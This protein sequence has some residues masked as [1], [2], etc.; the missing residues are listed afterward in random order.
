[1]IDCSHGNS[2]KQ[3]ENQA[4]VWHS[5]LQL[6][7]SGQHAVA[8]LMLESNLFEGNQSLDDASSGLRYGVSITDSCIGWDETRELLK[9]AAGRNS[10][11]C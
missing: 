11:H 7:A 10:R 8:G 2:G 1:M 9:A 6:R 5:A 4:T 3:F